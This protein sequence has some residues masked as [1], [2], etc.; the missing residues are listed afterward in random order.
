MSDHDKWKCVICDH[1]F[2]SYQFLTA[3]SP[4]D[5]EDMLYACPEC[6]YT[7]EPIGLCEENGCELTASC[8][9]PFGDGDYKHHCPLHPPTNTETEK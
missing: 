3:T 6:R 9:T 7:R 1:K 5:E 4:F 8:G 2:Y